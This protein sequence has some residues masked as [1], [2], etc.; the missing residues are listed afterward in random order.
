MHVSCGKGANSEHRIFHGQAASRR[1]IRCYI[2]DR[3][4][5]E[6]M[7]P[8]ILNRYEDKWFYPKSNNE[9]TGGIFGWSG[10][11]PVGR[12]DDPMPPTVQEF[13]L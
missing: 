6:W 12:L 1:R 9:F 8:I 7:R 10:P 2:Q 13:S 5:P 3:T 4:Q 11:L